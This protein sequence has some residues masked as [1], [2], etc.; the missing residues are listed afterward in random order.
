MGVESRDSAPRN[1]EN[2][3]PESIKR[4]KINKERKIMFILLSAFPSSR[5][6]SH[7]DGV[8]AA[9]PRWYTVEVAPLRV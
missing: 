6:W 7:G 9:T 5:L 1:P 8:L 4:I 2:S 3:A